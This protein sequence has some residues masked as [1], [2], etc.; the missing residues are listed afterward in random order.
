MR[1]RRCYRALAGTSDESQILRQPA[2]R[3]LSLADALSPIKTY[4]VGRAAQCRDGSHVMALAATYVY[5]A[6]VGACL[7][8]FKL[9]GVARSIYRD[10]T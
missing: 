8:A 9:R 6:F 5:D 10:M 2:A 1:G 4:A 3:R 7:Y